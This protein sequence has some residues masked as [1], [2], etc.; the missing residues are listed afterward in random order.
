MGQHALRGRSG[1][2]RN[3]TPPARRERRLVGNFGHL[4]GT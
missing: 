1:R 2:L 3:Q 4:D